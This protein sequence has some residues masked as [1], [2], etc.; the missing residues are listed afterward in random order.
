MIENKTG[1]D[2]VSPQECSQG[3]LHS[4]G[5]NKETGGALKHELFNHMYDYNPTSKHL[6]RMYL[7]AKNHSDKNLLF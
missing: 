6:V 4:L 2:V 3:L 5:K 1:I 7:G